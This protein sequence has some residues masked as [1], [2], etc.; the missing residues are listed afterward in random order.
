MYRLVQTTLF[1]NKHYYRQQ[2]CSLSKPKHQS[3]VSMLDCI[4]RLCFRCFRKSKATGVESC[5]LNGY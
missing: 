2:H 5:K 1:V 4:D 3:K